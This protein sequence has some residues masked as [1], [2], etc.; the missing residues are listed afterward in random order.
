MTETTT[1]YVPNYSHTATLYGHV[2]NVPVRRDGV[3]WWSAYSVHLGIVHLQRD[4]TEVREI[5]PEFL[6]E[7]ASWGRKG[8]K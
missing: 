3:Y 1:E 8:G 2:R 4:V 6:T 5:T 7:I